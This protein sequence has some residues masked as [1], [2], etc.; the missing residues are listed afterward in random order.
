MNVKSKVLSAGVLFF[1]G[2]GLSAQID[3]TKVKDIEEV[4]VVAYG[5]Q[6]KES[7]TG[8]VGEVKAAEIKNISAAN[9]V[10]GLTGKVAGVQVFTQNGLPG[11]APRVRFRGVGSI[12]TTS[13]PLYVVDGV[14]YTGNIAGINNNDIESMTFLKDAAASSLYGNRAANGVIIITTKKGKKGR[15]Q[16]NLDLKAGVASRGIPEYDILSS[17][18]EYYEVYHKMLKNNFI[19]N[20]Q[21]EAAAHTAAS[22][23]LITGSTGLGYNVTNVA[24]AEIIGLDGKFNP[25]ASIL[26]QED[27]KDYLF[28]DGFYTNT[29]FSASGA[30][31]NTTF[32]Y[33][34]GYESND[35]Y[36]VNS[37]WEKITGRMKLDTKLGDRI[38]FGGNMGYSFMEQNAPD[39]FDGSTAYSNPF[40]WTRNIAPIYPVHLYNAA[41][42]LQT[43]D[44]G[45]PLYD[46]G[47]KNID[48][49]VRQY[50][51]LQNPYA[52]ALLDI[53]KRKM[54]QIFAGA[55]GT[56]N[57]FDGLDFTYKITG[58]FYNN[59][60]NELDTPLYGDAVSPNGRLYNWNRN[61][62]SLNQQQLL[63][64]NK[65]FGEFSIGV[66]AAHE[67]FKRNS[68]YMETHVINGLLTNSV[69][70]DMFATLV[71]ARGNGSPYAL[72]SYFGRLNL[73]YADKYFLSGS[74]RRDGSSR[75]HP[76]NRWGTFFSVGGSWIVSKENWFTNN[77]MNFLKLK[78]SYG[79][80][81]NDNLSSYTVT[82]DFPYLN[83]YSVIQTTNQVDTPPYNMTFKGNPDITWETNENFNAGL[84]FGLFNDRVTVDAEYFNRTT[85]DLL[86]MRPYPLYTGFAEIPENIGDMR[87]RGVEV[88]LGIDVVKTSNFKLNLNGNT[89]YF[90]N[91]VLS[92]PTVSG[93]DFI[94]DGN[95]IMKAG[96]SRYTWYMREFAGVNPE[97]GAALWTVLNEAT[98]ERTT[99]EN[100]SNATL[101]D[102]GID[103]LPDFYGG[104]GLDL[105]YKNID[106]TANFAYQ[107]GGKGYD[108]MWMNLMKRSSDVGTNFHKDYYNTWSFDNKD[109]ALPIVLPNDA[110][111]QY[112]Q[113]TLGL[114]SSDYISLQNVSI[115]YTFD[116]DL[117]ANTGLAGLRLYAVADNLHVWSKRKGYDPRM[118]I[119]GISSSNYSP[120][121]TIS[122]GANV[123]F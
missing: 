89:T 70:S 38:K 90:K 106:F 80:V 22:N 71:D 99:T 118:N 44:N 76:D 31:D 64:Y 43:D 10:Q 33:S 54:N 115:G 7:L 35:T 74:I 59:R 14:P 13:E 75:F 4:V 121:R 102:T 72:D 95:Y 26:Y 123:T 63:E 41:G 30:T 83:L 104:F 98:G 108:S 82:R 36:M 79:E 107:F 92:I 60:A 16:F 110:T 112:S 39:G 23:G 93:R 77:F 73:D 25:N 117:L 49:R 114:I 103:A 46:D 3:T 113:S 57:I 20:G 68:D 96:Q 84:E 2:Q 120:I 5:A 56:V 17:P 37:K 78:A 9:V 119:T 66:L 47:T 55:Y 11:Q 34:L 67:S 65:N 122:V 87:N 12:N 116:K 62:S 40:Q 28:K 51:Q 91:E 42:I 53:K 58:E 48:G 86:Y 1:I 45:A 21:T 18:S 6:T 100:Y 19:N 27:W 61:I 109:A 32:F 101:I 50:G 105:K 81:G 29:Y 52:T 24:N 85:R 94:V 8:S 88:S 97:T 15:T 111:L 69:Y